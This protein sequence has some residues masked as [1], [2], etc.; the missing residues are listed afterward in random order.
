MATRANFIVIAKLGNFHICAIYACTRKE[1]GC[2]AGAR[3]VMAIWL[4]IRQ[5]WISQELEADS[6][7]RKVE[8]L[9]A[10]S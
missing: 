1:V 2:F 9:E 4:Q 5:E 7:M 3:H 10:D 8:I 6:F